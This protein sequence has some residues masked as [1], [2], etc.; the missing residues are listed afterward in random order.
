MV[1][2][3]ADAALVPQT[4]REF[5][6]RPFWSM[7]VF[8]KDNEGKVTHFLWRYGGRDYR[9]QRLAFGSTQ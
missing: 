1:A 5:F 7:I 9:A 6:D 2:P 8:V 3:G 4:A